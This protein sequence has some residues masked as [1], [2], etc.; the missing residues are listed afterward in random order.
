MKA[1][2]LLSAVLSLA[3]TPLVARLAR[4]CGAVDHPDERRTHKAPMPT[5]G[6]LAI[7][8]AFWVSL[9]IRDWPPSPPVLA[10][11]AASTVL[12]GVSFLDDLYGVSPLLR[13]GVQLVLAAALWQ[14]GGIRISGFTWPFGHAGP[15][16]VTLGGASLALTVLWIVL[17]TN[18]MNWLDGMD[19]LAGGV[20]AVAATTL[21]MLAGGLGWREVALM[22]AALAGA[23]LGFLRYN[24]KPARIFMGDTGAM[25]LG[26]ILACTAVMGPLKT[27]TSF[28]VL[29][30]LLAL[31][32]PIYDVVSTMARRMLGR[33]PVHLG[34]RQHLHHRLL[35]R[36]WSED[37]V[38]LVLWMIAG[39][40]GVVALFLGRI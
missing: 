19:G 7:F 4:H 38:V 22:G 14:V 40:L 33:H 17:I 24:V 11:L 35:G 21:A 8:A 12:A 3:L 28:T 2:F 6:G 9:L 23:A 25:F 15:H 18:A 30:P 37:I 5:C 34:D 32:V 26:L 36:G 1:A 39:A 13:L 31:G 10:L 27:A 20:A 16:Y 29:G